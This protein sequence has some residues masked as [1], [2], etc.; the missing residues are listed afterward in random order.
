MSDHKAT[1]VLVFALGLKDK[2]L[3]GRLRK[4]PPSSDMRIWMVGLGNGQPSRPRVQGEGRGW[5]RQ[6]WR[7]AQFT[8]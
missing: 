5:G 7:S 3:P 1:A 6:G 8:L 2:S 4:Q